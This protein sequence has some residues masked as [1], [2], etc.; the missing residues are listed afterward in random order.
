MEDA[1]TR[2][3]RRAATR[4]AEPEPKCHRPEPQKVAEREAK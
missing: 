3:R 1:V 2:T 4:A